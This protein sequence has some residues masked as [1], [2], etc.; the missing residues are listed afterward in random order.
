MVLDSE[1]QRGLILNALM[2]QP[3]QGDYQGIVEMLPKFTAVV[4]AVKTATIEEKKD[5]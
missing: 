2:S 1:D 3:I 4:E 5:G